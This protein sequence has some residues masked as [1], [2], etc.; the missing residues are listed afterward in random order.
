MLV[1]GMYGKGNVGVAGCTDTEYRTHF[2]LWCLLAAP[3]MIG[4]DVR[5]MTSFTQQLLTCAEAIAV[6]QD[7]LGVQARRVGEASQHGEVWVK[8]LADGS[9]A[10]GLFNRSAEGERIVPLPWESLGLHDRR[11]A[12]V[13]DLWAGEDLGVFRGSFSTKV[14]PHGCTLLRLIPQV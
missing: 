7:P 14:E 11:E 3:L 13:R 8:P 10:V 12:L 6:S 9:L 4:C 2:G 1:V 5:S